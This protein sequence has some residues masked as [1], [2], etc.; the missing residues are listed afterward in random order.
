MKKLLNSVLRAKEQTKL[1]FKS[2]RAKVDK[3]GRGREGRSTR[4]RKSKKK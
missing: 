3:L 2:K 4:L 1:G